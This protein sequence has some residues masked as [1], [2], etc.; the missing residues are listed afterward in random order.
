MDLDVGKI[1]SGKSADLIIFPARYFSELLSRSQHNRIVVRK[2]KKINTQLP[3]YS[4]LDD[5]INP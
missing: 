1:T 3:D 2:G 4:E 5:L